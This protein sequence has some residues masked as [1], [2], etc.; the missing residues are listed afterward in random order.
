M[1]KQPNILLF[2]PDGMQGRAL[3]RD[4]V[5][6]TPNFER[7]AQRGVRLANAH[8]VLPTC[9]PARASLMTGLLPHN[10]GVLQVEHCVDDDQSVLRTGHPHWAQRLSDAGY[11]TAYFGKWHIERS[12]DLSNFGW[13]INHSAGGKGHRKAA[14]GAAK[15][16]TG[17]VPLDPSLTRYQV[18]PDAY[19]RTLHYGV[20]DVPPSE[21]PLSVPTGQA[22]EF[23]AEAGDGKQPWCCC[24]SYFDPNEALIVGREAFDQYDVASLDLPANLRDDMSDR[25]NLY[26]RQQLIFEG[27]TD[28]EWRMAR[29]CYY[30][31]ITEIDEQFGRLVAQLES[32]GQID[33]TIVIVTADHGRYL[34]GHGMEAHNFGAFEEIYNIPLIAA[35]PGLAQGVESEARVGLLDL[36]PTIAELADAEAIEVPDSR[37]FASLLRDPEIEAPNFTTGYAEYHGTRFPLCQRVLWDGPWKFVFNGFDFDEL[38]NLE[39]DPW[40]MTNL[41][42]RAEH[43][44]K[45]R[46]MMSQIWRK[47]HGT[48]DDALLNTHYYSMRFAA[49]GPNAGETG[50]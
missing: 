48:G 40:E 3:A 2:V 34:G 41:A 47:V 25:P 42:Q 50:P 30:G 27:L 14:D 44:E 49:V 46:E 36:C 12:L 21:R 38:Y 29:A 31:R 39:D 7:L 1:A 19:N 16:T 37:S 10:H 13:Q 28:D 15:G 45:V 4:H 11:Q 8:T 9:S 32:T 17:D 24:V 33:N 43:A 5:C 26:R 22:C 18:G 6:R 23:L 20:T 35:G